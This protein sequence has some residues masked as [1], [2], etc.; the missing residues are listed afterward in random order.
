VGTDAIE[1]IT[2]PSRGVGE[3]FPQHLRLAG[4]L[5]SREETSSLACSTTRPPSWRRSGWC[6]RA[7]DDRDADRVL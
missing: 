5:F 2:P 6:S 7:C 1:S 3:G 4:K